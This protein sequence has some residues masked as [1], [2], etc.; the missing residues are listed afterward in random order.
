MSKSILIDTTRCVG[1]QRCVVACKLVNGLL[2]TSRS[3]FLTTDSLKALTPDTDLPM[4]EVGDEALP[5]R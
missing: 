4:D 2:K 3:D 5:T 1:C